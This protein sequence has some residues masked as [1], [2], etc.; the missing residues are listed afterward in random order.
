M[1]SQRPI[2]AV[3]TSPSEPAP[4]RRKI[5]KGT[6]SC[7]E[8]KKRKTRCHFANIADVVCAGCQRRGTTC[9][10]Q[11]YDDA[12]VGRKMEIRQDAEE[13]SWGAQALLEQMSDG[14]NQLT[15]RAEQ[16]VPE[17][18]SMATAREWNM[19]QAESTR[20]M[21][22]SIFPSIVS[23]PN[24]QV[25]D[26]I[27]LDGASSVSLE[28]TEQT[29]LESADGE[30]HRA[31]ARRLHA[32]LPSQ[33]DTDIIISAGHTAAFLQFFTLPY[34]ELFQNHMRPP[35]LLSALPSPSAHP[36]LL[37]R[38]LLYLVNGLQNLQPSTPNAH[39]LNLGRSISG[40]VKTYLRAAEQV[41]RNDQLICSQ[42]G[43]ECLILETVYYTNASDLRR[44]WMISRRAIGLAQLLGLHRGRAMLSAHP[45]HQT[46]VM[47][48]SV[49]WHR[50]VCHDRYLA[51]M[52]GLP[53][54][55]S[56]C[57]NLAS[58]R[59]AP[60]TCPCDHL[61][62]IHS[63]AMGR[64]AARNANVTE[65]LDEET[66]KSID[67][68]LQD[69]AQ[70]MPANWWLIPT[71]RRSHGAS[72]PDGRAKLE[73]I[74]RILLQITHFNL[75]IL[76]YLPY[77]LRPTG[78]EQSAYSRVAC[79]N[80]SRELLSRYIKFRCTNQ[81]VFCCRSIDFAACTASLAVLLSHIARW[82]RGADVADFLVHQRL[83]DRAL[84]DET[85]DLMMEADGA[86][87]DAQLK[88]T[89]DILK[90]LADMEAEA[91][92]RGEKSPASPAEAPQLQSHCRMRCLQLKLPS[93]GTVKITNRGI[94]C[95]AES[96]LFSGSSPAVGPPSSQPPTDHYNQTQGSP[97]QDALCD[98]VLGPTPQ[99]QQRFLDVNF[100]NFEGS[101]GADPIC[102]GFQGVD[103]T[104]F[105]HLL[106]GNSEE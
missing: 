85:I 42:E 63:H 64:I 26:N 9:I 81:I 80:A 51:L 41:T 5:R 15:S 20:P 97:P 68:T 46:S 27:L 90:A 24:I 82:N 99:Q 45:D 92:A 14:A 29:T 72:S 10:T 21:S 73:D 69:A 34:H 2:Q 77:M 13:R 31:L 38:T 44:A 75:L 93:L 48:S 59:L 8:C 70:S 30:Q 50:L 100:N 65:V 71:T 78:N 62:R 3:E 37:A 91:A 17:P 106:I 43:L 28:N 55:M 96:P 95:S 32:S 25:F 79:V 12:D 53:G 61:E 102:W 67:R 101:F 74:L 103:S 35:S 23:L 56:P 89:S 83:S 47:T 16:L 19:L 88:Q 105:N 94:S 1:P 11:E 57:L 104:P 60:G 33:R 87:N 40:A 54:M 58:V 39:Q 86:S 98:T 4:K 18:R 76:L 36:V 84:V 6:T 66:T 49:M 52:L 22:H 7:W